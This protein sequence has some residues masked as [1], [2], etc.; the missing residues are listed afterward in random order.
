MTVGIGIVG[1]GFMSRTYAY[2]IRELVRGA[3]C[4]A[5]TGGSRAPALAADFGL[6]LEPSL[7]AMLA[8]DD[9]DVV[10]LG[11]PTQVHHEQTLAA[12]RTGRHVFTEKPIAATLPE[13]DAMIRATREARVLLWVNAV[14]RWRRGVRMAKE[15]VDSGEIGEI[16]M[17]R[18]TYAFPATG[19]ADPDHWSNQP[20]A[21]SPFLDQGAH[22]NDLIRWS[23]GADAVT[24]YA[25]YANYTQTVPDGQSAMIP[26]P[27][28]TG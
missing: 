10:L 19:Y 14:S 20:G 26:T 8:R 17:V 1:A 2:G 12:A 27:S 3:R 25:R 23:V 24:A 5:V 6:V 15:L 18:H 22:C 9:V 21:G 4:V 16:R 7:D 28:R 11:S 13:I